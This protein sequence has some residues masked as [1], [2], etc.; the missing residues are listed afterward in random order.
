MLLKNVTFSGKSIDLA[1]NRTHEDSNVITILMGGNSSGKSR[2]FQTICSAFIRTAYRRVDSLHEL[3]YISNLSDIEQ[4]DSISYMQDNE[5]T[6]LCR[7]TSPYHKKYNIDNSGYIFLSSNYPYKN[8][9]IIEKNNINNEDIINNIKYDFLSEAKLYSE[10]IQFKKN[11]VPCNEISMPNKILAVTCS[12]YDKFPFII[13][14][15]Y[16]PKLPQYFYLGARQTKRSIYRS[17]QSYLGYKFDQLGASFI[18]LLLKP[19]QEKFDFSKMLNFLNISGIFTLKLRFNELLSEKE[20][21]LETVSN[22]MSKINMLKGEDHGKSKNE[23]NSHEAKIK[24]LEA[25][26]NVIVNNSEGTTPSYFKEILCIM[27]L[28]KED[29]DNIRLSYLEVLS[30]YG[31]IELE[32][33]IFHKLYSNHE[34]LLSQASSGE[35][36][37]LFTMSSI[38]GEIQNNSLI[39]IDEPELS[40]HPK[41]QLNFISLLTDIFSGYKSCH[42]IIA[43]HSPNIVSSLPIDDAYIVHLETNDL[44]LKPSKLYHHRSSD[45]QLAEVF[46]SPG[47][48]NEYLISQVIEVLD[49]ICKSKTLDESIFTKAEWLMSFENKVGENDRVKI[50]LNILQ[51]TIEALKAK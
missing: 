21:T 46:D 20:V 22:L 10:Y 5:I 18:K 49:K 1:K 6:S 17:D 16:S 40:L 44:K 32:D 9:I 42:F 33:I 25:I 37:L 38:A 19:K 15:R 2:I 50:L 35:L 45:F 12:P 27:D 43:T 7:M 28:S 34:F 4:F 48:N 47:N 29:N 26:R 51:Q 24:V 11:G 8:A 41:W 36:S 3:R 31:L 23:S 39:L 14:N 30:E 13:P